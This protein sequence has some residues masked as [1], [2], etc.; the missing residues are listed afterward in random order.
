M[1]THPR[2]PLYHIP[3]PLF[4]PFLTHTSSVCHT[5]ISPDLI[6]IPEPPYRW[7]TCLPDEVQSVKNP[8]C[9]ETAIKADFLIETAYYYDYSSDADPDV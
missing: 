3:K 8:T 6:G 2:I 4:I 9:P 1:I 5:H 7:G